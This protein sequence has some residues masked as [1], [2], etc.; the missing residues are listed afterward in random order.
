[1][2][3]IV[4]CFNGL[5]LLLC[6]PVMQQQ[7]F[8]P[9][10]CML[11]ARMNDHLLTHTVWLVQLHCGC[12]A[13]M[14]EVLSPPC[15]ADTLQP[16]HTR[17]AGLRW[18]GR[19][20]SG[21]DDATNTANLAI[22]LMHQGVQLEVTQVSENIPRSFSPKQ[23]MQASSENVLCAS[24]AHAAAAATVSSVDMDS[25]QAAES[26][27]T[28]KASS[29][30]R[31][32][33]SSSSPPPPRVSSARVSMTQLAAQKG[34]TGVFDASGKWLGRCFCGTKAKS[35]V[36][37]RPGQNHGRQFWSCGCWT[38]TAQQSSSCGFFLWADEVPPRQ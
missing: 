26:A 29:S 8:V 18:S 19:A 2:H 16:L 6:C 3:E 25:A 7:G 12:H 28:N 31:L 11:S 37:K 15:V 35:R 10:S 32:G 23:P 33:P 27:G 17:L 24:Q 14:T 22:H 21:L 34:A 36:T 4:Y 5:Q 1:M 30:D 13:I 20:H 9:S 38:I